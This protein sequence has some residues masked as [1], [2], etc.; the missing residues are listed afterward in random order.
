MEFCIFELVLSTKFQLDNFE[1]LDQ[2]Y[3]Q[4]KVFP[5]E[6]ITSSPRTTSVC[7]FVVRNLKL[8]FRLKFNH[9]FTNHGYLHSS[10]KSFIQF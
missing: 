8:K 2:I 6:S 1:F 10:L 7:V 4:K 5:V 3:P 9:D